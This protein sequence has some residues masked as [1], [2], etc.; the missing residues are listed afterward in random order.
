MADNT[1]EVEAV[2]AAID[3]ERTYTTDLT[4]RLV[5]IPSVNPKFVKDESI[6]REGE[7]QD[8]VEAELKSLGMEIDRWDALPGRPNVVG[9]ISGTDDRSLILNGHIDVV[10]VGDGWTVDPFGA[11]IKDGKIFGRGTIDMKAGVAA[12][13]A[14]VRGIRAAGIELQGKLALHSVVDEEAGGFGTIEAIKRGHLAKTAVVTEASH[15]T[16]QACEGGL[17]WIRVTIMGKQGHSA[18]RYN[19]IW[20]QRDGAKRPARSVNAIDIAARFLV[21]LKEFESSICR[22]RQHALLP[23]GMNS[24][25]IGSVR[26]GAGIGADGLP[27]I[28]TNPAIVPDVAVI[29]IDLKF[30]PHQTKDEV[31][32]EFEGFVHHFCQQD[33]WLRDNPIKVEWELGGLHFPPMNTAPDHPIAKALHDRSAQL[34]KDGIITGMFA[35]TDAAHYAGAGVD[36]LIYGPR[37]DGFHASDEFVEIAS[38][39]AV[40]K[41]LAASIIDYCGIR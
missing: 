10:P 34:G 25:N 5:R 27:I 7:V 11:E 13:I 1:K 28:M 20:P 38:M 41:I 21:A 12:A 26:A 35:V 39:E 3:K 14:A 22:Y 18:L 23:P 32:A 9:T 31:R 8:V 33:L 36:A 4:Q 30:L 15:E 37:G 29:D 6:N 24:I 40:T 2:W 17:E 19:D 16:V